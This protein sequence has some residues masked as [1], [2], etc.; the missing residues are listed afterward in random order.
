MINTIKNKAAVRT[1]YYSRIRLPRFRPN[2]VIIEIWGT[3]LIHLG[4][5]RNAREIIRYNKVK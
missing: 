5:Q 1:V 2:E 3:K 4:D